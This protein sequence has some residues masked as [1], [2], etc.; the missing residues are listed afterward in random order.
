MKVKRAQCAYVF[1]VRGRQALGSQGEGALFPIAP[2]Y[3]Q[4]VVDEVELHLEVVLVKGHGTCGE[5][6][7]GEKER[8]VPP[9][10]D[11]RDERE[12]GLAQQLAP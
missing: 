1:A 5:P 3:L 12:A 11:G 10:V 8:R 4:T 9:V 2:P 6:P 7:G